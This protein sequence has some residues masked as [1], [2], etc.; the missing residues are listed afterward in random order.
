MEEL[1]DSTDGLFLPSPQY[2][3]SMLINLALPPPAPGL[4]SAS[5]SV[6]DELT[7]GLFVLGLALFVCFMGCVCVFCKPKEEH[8]YSAVVVEAD[9]DAPLEEE[10][11]TPPIVIPTKKSFSNDGMDWLNLEIRTRNCL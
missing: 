4:G 5:I 11:D 3:T 6:S 9:M 2:V 8:L 1:T 7:G 10:E